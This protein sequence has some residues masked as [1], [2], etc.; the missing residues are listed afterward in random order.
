M[1]GTVSQ[2]ISRWE[3][4]VLLLLIGIAIGF[5]VSVAE[6]LTPV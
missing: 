4:D 2:S 5:D 6:E 1:I 3:D